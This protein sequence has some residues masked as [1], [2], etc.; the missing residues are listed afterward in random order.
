MFI[1]Y[2][3]LIDMGHRICRGQLRDSVIILDNFQ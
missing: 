3:N 2:H 1:I